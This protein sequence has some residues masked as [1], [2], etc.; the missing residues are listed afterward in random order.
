V[1]ISQADGKIKKKRSREIKRLTLKIEIL[2]EDLDE[3]NDILDECEL[4]YSAVLTVLL[5]YFKKKQTKNLP[6]IN[7]KKPEPN[8]DPDI[9]SI[10]SPT[11]AKKLFKKIAKETHPDKLNHLSTSDDE[12]D[13]KKK[14]YINSLNSINDGDFGSLIETALELGLDIKINHNEIKGYLFQKIEKIKSQVEKIQSRTS[15]IWFHCDDSI[16]I[17]LIKNTCKTYN[18]IPSEEDMLKIMKS[19]KERDL[20]ILFSK[21]VDRKVGQRPS[22]LERKQ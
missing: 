6:A 1:S 13:K 15:W 21:R 22:R 18:I 12:K 11:W 19:I 17:S 2:T 5:S 10:K 20:T 14:M 7:H 4:D 16:R 9:E 3:Y 8:I